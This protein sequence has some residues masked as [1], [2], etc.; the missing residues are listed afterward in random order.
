MAN[1]HGREAAAA[2]G[3]REDESRVRTVPVEATRA[4]SPPVS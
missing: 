3:P 4:D 2:R 1:E